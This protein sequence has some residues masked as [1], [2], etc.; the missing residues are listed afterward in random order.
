MSRQ[1]IYHEQEAC[2]LDRY[3]KDRQTA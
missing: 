2:S 1:K 3:I